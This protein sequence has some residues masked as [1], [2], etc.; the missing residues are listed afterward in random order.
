MTYFKYN[1]T[2]EKYLLSLHKSGMTECVIA[3]TFNNKYK[4]KMTI[5]A[6]KVKL[7]R[8]RGMRE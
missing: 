8:L 5:N 1:A 6:L 3:K 4:C 7:Q 2:S